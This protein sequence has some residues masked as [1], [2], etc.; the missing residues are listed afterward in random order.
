V[1]VAHAVALA[2]ATLALALSLRRS[3]LF[4]P[5]LLLAPAALAPPFFEWTRVPPVLARLL[6][7]AHG[8]LLLAIAV[9]AWLSRSM[10]VLVLDPTLVPSLGAVLL[11]PLAAAFALAPRSFAPGTTLVPG[12]IF[13]LG[14]AG[15]NPLPAGYGGSLLPFLK[16]GDHNAF[17]ELY[18]GLAVVV[19][20]ALWVAAVADRGPRW[21]RRALATLATSAVVAGGLAAAGVIGLPLAQPQVERAFASALASGTS[22]LS[23]ETSLGE[24]GSL[25]LSRR[26]VLDVQ[27]SVP[28]GGQWRLASELFTRFDGRRWTNAATRARPQRIAAGPAPADSGPLLAGLGSWF[29]VSR[30]D[31]D[32]ERVEGPRAALRIT[33]AEVT[34]W[35]LLV[36]REA[37]AVTASAHALER[38]RF[39]LV[40]R[41]PGLPL[42]QYGALLTRRPRAGRGDGGPLSQ[43]EREEAL[44]LHA[45]VDPRMVELARN[46]APRAASERERLDATVAHLQANYLYSLTPGPFRA[47]GDPLAEFLFEKKQAYCEYFA[48]AAV[49]LLRLQG[50]P[51]RLVKGLSVGP[52]TDM[53]GGLHV[54]R[55]SDA[56][57]WIEAWIPGQGWVEADPTPPGQFEAARGQ[58]DRFSRILEQTRAALAAA[59]AR[60]TA[61]GPLEFLRWIGAGALAWLAW[62]VRE[63]LVWLAAA[64]L[65]LGPR[66]A[67]RMRRALRRRQRSAAE[68][69]ALVRELERRWSAHG[70]PRPA[71]RGLLEHGTALAGAPPAGLAPV[72][73]RL[74]EAGTRI[75][76]A[77]YRSR[78]GGETLPHADVR[79]LHDELRGR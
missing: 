40:R 71:G 74:A 30:E 77:Y 46:L 76:R 12:T 3:A 63:P 28:S 54:V 18:L 50:V 53:G 42:Y 27:S 61:A 65:V 23:G 21:S 44:Q 29:P 9:V 39:G 48:S 51:A 67:R 62:A 6:P 60:L 38:D 35:P 26:R 8:A 5:L 56:H 36:P 41:P 11:V 43:Q 7:R 64:A 68:L 66:A 31:G 1:R 34:N 4:L 13:L 69:R 73:P 37:A 70:R 22:G 72:P 24:I 32:S 79:R 47:D 59:W 33:Q 75:V 17:A 19:A 49:V 20:A 52:Q 45:A 15:L 16:G 57:A 14:L 58:P 25:A 55:E 78:Y 2:A 10:G